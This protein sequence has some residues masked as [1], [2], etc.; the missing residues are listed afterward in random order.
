MTWMFISTIVMESCGLFVHGSDLFGK[1]SFHYSLLA[2]A[3]VWRS[4]I[5]FLHIQSVL[6]VIVLLLAPQLMTANFVLVIPGIL[7]LLLGGV[8]IALLC[9]MLCLRFRDV[10]GDNQYH[11]DRSAHYA[12][13]L[14]TQQPGGHIPPRLCRVQSPLSGH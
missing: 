14:A 7:L 1:F 6:L 4:F 11:A 3:L 13:L 9:G 2:Y 12:Y 5:T 10:T 8:P